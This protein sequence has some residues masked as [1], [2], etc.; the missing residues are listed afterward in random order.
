MSQEI[1]EDLKKQIE[2]AFQYR[3]HVTITFKDGQSVDGYI[4]NREFIN[5]KISEDRFIDVFLKGSGNPVRYK[6]PTLKSVALTGTDEAEGKS[7][8]DW[9]KKQDKKKPSGETHE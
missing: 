6:I 8:Q 4:Y 3:G 2:T 9:M 5:P 7:Y 1:S